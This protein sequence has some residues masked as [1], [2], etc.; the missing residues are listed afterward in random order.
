MTGPAGACPETAPAFVFPG[1][2]RK[3]KGNN[4]KGS[5]TLC[6]RD[7]A[8]SFGFQSEAADIGTVLAHEIN[9]IAPA[10]LKKCTNLIHCILLLSRTPGGASCSYLFFF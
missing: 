3:F 5:R 7:P 4:A 10:V 9:V 1:S 2:G 6:V 8:V